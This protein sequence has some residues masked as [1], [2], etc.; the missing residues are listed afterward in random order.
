MSA[1]FWAEMSVATPRTLSQL[2]SSFTS[3]TLMVLN[4]PHLPVGV[5]DLL[6]G[7]E[8][9]APGQHDLAVVVDEVTHLA[10]I[11]I[12]IGVGL[13]DHAWHRGPVA[14]GQRFVR[15]HEAPIPVLDE[16]HARLGIDDPAEEGA[17]LL[18]HG[19]DL[20]ALGQDPG[21]GGAAVPHCSIADTTWRASTAT[22][23]LVRVSCRGTWSR[24]E[25]VPTTKPSGVTSGA[26]A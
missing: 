18:Q 24:I 19:L 12:E 14:A 25:R 11:G 7:D 2:P 20:L 17:L 9:Y 6:L 22:G 4:Q 26:L 8:L 23:R 1:R 3:G 15:Q 10:G 21:L 13:A 16:H 5:G